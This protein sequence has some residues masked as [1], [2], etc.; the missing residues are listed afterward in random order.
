LWFY[1][2]KYFILNTI[3][4]NE[5]FKKIFSSEKK[6]LVLANKQ[7]TLD[8]GLEKSKQNFFQVTKPLQESRRDEE[9]LDNLEEILVASDV[10]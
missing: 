1:G 7:E 5:F 8:K 4:Y 2:L 6:R 10:V 9:V 3:S